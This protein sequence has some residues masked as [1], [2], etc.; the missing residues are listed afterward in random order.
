[1]SQRQDILRHLA[2]GRTITP[3]EALSR[4]GCFRLAARIAEIREQGHS[5]TRDTVRTKGGARVARYR[6]EGPKTQKA[7]RGLLRGG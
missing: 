2:K 6:I 7:P 4:F 1:M 3:L 5:V